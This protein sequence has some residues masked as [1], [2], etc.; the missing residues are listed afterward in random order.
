MTEIKIAQG[1]KQTGGKLAG[2]KV[3]ADV[4]YYRGVEEGKDIFSPNRFPYADTTQHLL[5]FVEKLQKLSKKPVGFKI[6]I[7]DAASVEELAQAI[8]TRKKQGLSTPDFIT[9]DSGEGGSATAPLEL[10]ESVGLTTNNALYLIDTIF[11]KYEIRHN[12]KLIASGKILTPDDAIITMCMGADAVGIARGFMMS[13]GCIRARM[14]S[15]FG[16]H[17]CPVGMATQDE[18]KR[19]SYLVVKQGKEIGNYHKNLLASMKVVLAVMGVKNIKELDKSHL[20]FKN[21]NGEIFFDIDKYFHH[22][23]HL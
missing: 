11:K 6:V 14:C 17:V 20:T 3:T 1:A 19:A 21:R 12:V 4:A 5:E 13:G 22:K 7:S 16:S 15:G 2:S 8:A 9:I 10:M 23:L 18:K